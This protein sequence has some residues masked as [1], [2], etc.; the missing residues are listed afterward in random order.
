M[1]YKTVTQ[2]QNTENNIKC[3]KTIKTLMSVVVL[4]SS[5]PTKI[6][7]HFPVLR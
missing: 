2:K 1:F 6:K 5:K 4:D 7:P 3:K